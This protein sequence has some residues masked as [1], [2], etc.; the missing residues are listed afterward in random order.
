[1]DFRD[2]TSYSINTKAMAF[3]VLGILILVNILS[4][5]MFV[6]FDWTQGKQYSISDSTKAL[7]TGL[8]D[9]VTV[10]AYFTEDLPPQFISLRQYVKDILSEYKA[11]SAG[12]FDYEFVDPMKDLKH[13]QEAQSIGVQQVRMQ[14]REND[15]FQVQN[16]YL[17]LGLFY[18]GRTESIPVI[19]QEDAANLEYDLTSLI[20][21][22]TKPKLHVVGFLKGHG[23]HTV[24]NGIQVAGAASQDTYSSVG[25]YLRKNYDVRTID[26]S[27]QQT[28]D[29]VDVL[30][31]AGPKRD[32]TERAV[33]EIDQF[34]LRGGKAIFLVDA[35][36]Q[37][38]T[39]INLEVLDINAKNLL[40]PLGLTVDSNL[41]LDALSE[42]A[43]FSEGPGRF[44][45]LQFPPFIR[46]V[47]ENFSSNPIVTKIQ[48]FVVRFVSSITVTEVD[49]LIY[50]RIVHTSPSSWYQEYPFQVNPS[51]IPQPKP[52]QGGARPVVV[53]VKGFLPRI[54]SS[55]SVPPLQEWI[56]KPGTQDYELKTV[57]TDDHRRGRQVSKEP[58]AES[59]VILF[60][61]SDFITDGALQNDQAS[62]VL[63]L[64]AVD[65]LTLGDTL[66]GI[67][68]KSVGSAAIR[69]LEQSEKTLMRYLGIFLVPVLLSGYGFIRLWVRRK[70]E[71]LLKL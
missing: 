4:T 10:K 5:R 31:V 24:G 69:E 28:L 30:V 50:D 11:Y 47:A 2:K 6:R 52:E 43:N 26:F 67:R 53:S 58:S 56:Q 1:M 62:L 39:G 71:R 33:F 29:S 35:I 25:Q 36:R 46:L 55:E 49:G 23:E 57:S 38:E 40:S 15:S 61:D 21:K 17:G 68:S 66:I 7:L 41:M 27:Q 42:L 3:I 48:S 65:S 12:N 59:Q 60:S 19:Q 37:I 44:Y 8:D 64:N 22:M 9:I 16:G 45:F 20:I 13:A 54:S 18:E 14:I 34:L 51:S 63:F 70:E 32:L